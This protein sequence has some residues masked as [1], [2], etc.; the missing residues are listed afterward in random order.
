MKRKS[1]VSNISQQLVG[2]HGTK[3]HSGPGMFPPQLPPNTSFL[4]PRAMKQNV[5]KRHGDQCVCP[6]RTKGD[7]IRHPKGHGA[8]LAKVPT[9]LMTVVDSLGRVCVGDWRLVAA[10][11]ARMEIFTD[12]STMLVCTSSD[13]WLL[14]AEQQVMPLRFHR[15]AHRRYLK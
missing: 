6:P 9:G 15:V 4:C 14:A 8:P 13:I 3:H 1:P 12:E 11:P 2:S 5:H 10:S 7:K